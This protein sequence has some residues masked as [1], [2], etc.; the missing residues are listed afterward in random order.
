M[1]KSINRILEDLEKNYLSVLFEKIWEKKCI[2]K[3]RC[4]RRFEM[5]HVS[6]KVL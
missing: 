3:C 4:G 2:S 1:Y 6:N 5:E